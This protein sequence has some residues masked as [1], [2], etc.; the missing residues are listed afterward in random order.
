MGDHAFNHNFVVKWAFLHES[1]IYNPVSLNITNTFDLVE[2]INT[3][4]LFCAE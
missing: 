4:A 3:I 1:R 2:K